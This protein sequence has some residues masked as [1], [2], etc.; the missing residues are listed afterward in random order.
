MKPSYTTTQSKYTN[1]LN[2]SSRA[3]FKAYMGDRKGIGYI[4][5]Y[6]R[7]K[8]ALRLRELDI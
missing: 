3:I 5:T 1:T 4:L 8:T 2:T 6:I 7:Q